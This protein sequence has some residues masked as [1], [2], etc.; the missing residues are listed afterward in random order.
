MRRGFNRIK[1][2]RLFALV[3]FIIVFG[4]VGWLQAVASE[5]LSRRAVESRT[6]ER[7]IEP[8]RGNI[9][10]ATGKTLATSVAAKSV[11]LEPQTYRDAE[12]KFKSDKDK[13]NLQDN[14]KQLA[15]S[16]QI[17]WFD[18]QNK[19]NSPT[20]WVPLAR[21]VD[22]AKAEAIKKLNIPGVGFSEDSKR[23]YPMGGLAAPVLGIVNV[24][25]I[26]IEGLEFS[27]DKVLYGQRGVISE[28][29]DARSSSLLG[30][31]HTY[32]LPVNGNN[33]QLT[34]DS[35]I[36]YI[37]DQQ[38]NNLVATS[39][40]KSAI[41]IVMDPKTG[42][43]LAMA[44]RPS[45]DPNEYTKFAEPL[46]RNLSITGQYEPGSTFKVITAATALEEGTTSPGKV[47]ND[48]GYLVVDRQR[49]TNWDSGYSAPGSLTFTEAMEQSSNVVLG[50]VGLELGRET[51]FKYIRGFGFGQ[52]TGVD[53]PG[54]ATG[55][56]LKEQKTSRFEQAT[57]AFGQANAATPLQVLTAISAVAN[58]GAL[59]KP[60]VVDKI[61][62]DQGQTV[63]QNSPTLVRQ[64]VSKSTSNQLK[65]ILE[66]VVL[67]GTGQGAKLEG[68]RAA[69]KTG[70]AQKVDEE[71]KYS[72]KDYIASFVG[73]APVEDPKVSVIVII[74]SPRKG[75]Y[76]GG[77]IAAPVFQ[78]IVQ[79]VL[80]YLNVPPSNVQAGLPLDL[81]PQTAKPQPKPVTPERKPNPGE[82]VV[83]DLTGRTMSEVGEM[84]SQ[85]GLRMNFVGTGLVVNQDYPPGK[86]VTAGTVITV[87][88]EP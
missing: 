63:K 70:T 16:L 38:L 67:V 42:K 49:I 30:G 48:P 31:I 3:F 59:V 85:Q 80:T 82:G 20:Q 21:Q 23:V 17:K 64:V 60:Y 47:Y 86:V 83:P 54:E 6:T 27:Y 71:G 58:G 37:V 75:G 68:Y 74:D 36:Q 76:H 14:L 78:A 69:G 24:D 72:D 15:D 46:R 41:V 13:Q 84:L 43:L 34:I 61:T 44:N 19:L 53:L 2:L 65:Q 87:K 50:Q 7:R 66:R 33:L 56:L 12:K 79:P 4:R 45:F 25:G 55:T 62:D 28:E 9:L 51:F 35:N 73:F 81:Q 5:D 77:E 40:P 1:F 39:D 26:G 22:L 8:K 11:F 10:D 57:M 52:P 18:L 29:T 88:F 32:Q